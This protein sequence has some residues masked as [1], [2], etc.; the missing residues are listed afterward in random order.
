M[1]RRPGSSPEERVRISLPTSE[2]ALAL[3]DAVAFQ[4][5]VSRGVFAEAAINQAVHRYLLG[6]SDPLR[7]VPTYMHRTGRRFVADPKL[8]VEAASRYHDV[9]FPDLATLILT[10]VR[11]DPGDLRRKHQFDPANPL[12]YVIPG[13]RR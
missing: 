12:T 3:G 2:G 1:R 11:P 7:P 9:S 6:I 10:N 13:R 5:G 8:F 4:L